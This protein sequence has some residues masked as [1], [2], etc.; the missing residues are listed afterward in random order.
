MANFKDIIT[1]ENGDIEI[2]NGDI[3]VD[4]S[5]SQHI[6]FIVTADKGQF[7]QFP[8]VG[9]GL[10]R[11]IN[12]PFNAQEIRQAIKLNLESDGYNVR[13]VSI[14]NNGTGSINIDATRKNI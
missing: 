12:G 4:L 2:I 9:V 6:D 1:D 13:K 3:N 7:R 11:Y 10:R 8:L 14:A 5:D